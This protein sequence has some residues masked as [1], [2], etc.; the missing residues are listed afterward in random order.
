M[1]LF[2]DEL[3]TVVGAGAA[4]GAIDASNMMKPAL[5]RGELQCVGATTLDEYRKHIEKDAALERRF[6]PILVDEP[7]VEETIAILRGPARQVRGAPQ[8][9]DHRRRDRRGSRALPP[10]HQRPLPARQGHRPDRRGGQ[11][12]P[13]GGHH[14]CRRT[15]ARWSCACRSSRARARPPCRRRTTSAPHELKEQTRQDPEHLR[16]PPSDAWLADKGIADATVD[17]DDIAELV[18]QVDRHPGAAHAAGGGREAARHGGEA[19]RARH[20]PGRAPS[21]P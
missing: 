1:I 11:Q 4:E 21:R 5:A 19:A 7:T 2:I 3:H 10:L 12:A 13:R 9:H 15:C 18:S 14:R 16:E 8:G 6:Q 20:R 17:A